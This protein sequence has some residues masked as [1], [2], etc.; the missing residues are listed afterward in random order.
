MFPCLR[1]CLRIWSRETA[2]AVLSRVNLLI[3]IPML[4]LVLT[5]EIPPDLGGGV[6]LFIYNRHTS[7][8][9]SRVYWVTQLRTEGISERVLASQVTFDQ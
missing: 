7:S 6:H 8:G 5:Y 9:Q 2:S 4:N 3:S 1:S